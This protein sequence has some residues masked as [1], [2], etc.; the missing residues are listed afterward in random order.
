M[1]FERAQQIFN[2]EEII[3][4][5]HD[6]SPIWIESLNPKNNMIT[7]KKLDGPDSLKEVPVTELVE[8]H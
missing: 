4:V 7:I 6:G 1:N 8:N 2:S 5:L 3:E